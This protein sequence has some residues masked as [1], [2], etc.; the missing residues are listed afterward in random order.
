MTLDAKLH[1]DGKVEGTIQS[2]EDVSIGVTGVVEATVSARNMVI[3]G[4]LKGSVECDHVEVAA[5]GTL[6]GNVTSNV[7]VVEPGARFDGENHLRSPERTAVA[8]LSSKPIPL[9]ARLKREGGE[10]A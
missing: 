2:T 10:K 8:R 3:C 6:I 9:Q 1:V 5:G 7:F 4:F